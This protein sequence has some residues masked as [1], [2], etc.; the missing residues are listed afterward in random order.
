MVVVVVVPLSGYIEV[1]SP[2]QVYPVSK[3]FFFFLW[4]GDRASF[5]RFWHLG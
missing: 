2:G 5:L 1:A 4:S 3:F